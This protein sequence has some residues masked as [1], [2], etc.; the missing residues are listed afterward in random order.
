MIS[1]SN[2]VS[3]I[4]R[5]IDISGIIKTISALSSSISRILSSDYMISIKESFAKLAQEYEEAHN[6]PYSYINFYDYQDTL[7]RFHW[8]WPF[9]ITPEELKN[10]IEQ[11]KDEREFDRLLASYF[12]KARLRNMFIIIESRL[13]RRH[14][15]ILR[16]IKNAFYSRQYALMNTATVAIMDNILGIVLRDKGC[17]A[18]KEILKPIIEYYADNYSFHDVDFLFEL[19]MLSNNINLIFGDYD[20]GN[21]V[22]IES[23]KKIRRH[24]SVHGYMFS[25]SRID[26]IMLLN[27]LAALL[28]NMKYILPFEKTI[29]RNKKK[30]FY[31]YT[32]DYVIRNRIQKTLE[33][34]IPE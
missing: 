21:K 16:Q 2:A 23:N 8:A 27:T 18:R 28:L 12:T 30:N 7:N 34:A 24:L 15:V 10:L 9:E 17:N 3:S 6:N 4:M 31:I 22:I 5:E 11:V 26:S 1:F 19:Q 14:R 20:F 33:I 25:N 13:S 32:K 29:N